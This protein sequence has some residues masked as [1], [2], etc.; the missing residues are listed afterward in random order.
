M[1]PDNVFPVSE[2][3]EPG[4]L[5]ALDPQEPGKLRRTETISDPGVVGIVAGDP[6]EVDG[7]LQA[8]VALFGLAVVKADASYA[9]IFAGDLLTTSP[10]PGH[11]MAAIAPA[12]GTVIGKALEPLDIG[13]G[14]IRVVDMLR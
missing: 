7:D 1:L 8:P 11:A 6:S 13:T 14:M 9:A 2:A 4:D 5:V 10:T 12:P 3:V